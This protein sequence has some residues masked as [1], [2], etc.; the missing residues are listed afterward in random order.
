[1]DKK[2]RKVRIRQAAA[3][4]LHGDDPQNLDLVA[5]AEALDES[6]DDV[7]AITGRRD[8]FNEHVFLVGVVVG[9]YGGRE[10]AERY[11]HSAMPQPNQGEDFPFVD[12]W[13]IAEDDRHDGSDLGSAIFIPGDGCDENRL[14]QTEARRILESADTAKRHVG[15]DKSV[16]PNGFSVVKRDPNDPGPTPNH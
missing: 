8:S 5:L 7:E 13:W 10:H 14:S 9:T 4:F 16:A 12:S 15:P 1:M 2:E 3:C 11:L 6:P